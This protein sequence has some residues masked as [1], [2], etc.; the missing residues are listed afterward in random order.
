M[1]CLMWEQ[2]ETSGRIFLGASSTPPPPLSILL[3]LCLSVSL[4]VSLSLSLS[5]F[6]HIQQLSACEEEV[7]EEEAIRRKQSNSSTESSC[8]FRAASHR[9]VSLAGIILNFVEF[10]GRRLSSLSFLRLRIL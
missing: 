6:H 9:L 3:S 4:S 5:L 7:E 2:H 10:V 1:E 8:V